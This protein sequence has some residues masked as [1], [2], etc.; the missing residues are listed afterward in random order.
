MKLKIENIG[1]IAI[2]AIA[3]MAFFYYL[4]GFSGMMSVFGIML[5]F[6]L[7]TYL[8]L[9]SFSLEQDEKLI[10]SFFIGVGIFPSITY[11]LGMFISFRIAILITFFLLL[12]IG[13]WFS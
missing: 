13:I 8:I 9:N 7:P 10:F 2:A 1:F 3:A 4:L 5:L 11:W 12:A 6:M